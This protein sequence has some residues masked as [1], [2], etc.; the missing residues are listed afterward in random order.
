MRAVRSH[1]LPLAPITAGLAGLL[2]LAACSGDDTEPTPTPSTSAETAEAPEPTG[3][4]EPEPTE[5]ADDATSAG[6]D[7]VQGTWLSDPAAQAEQTTSGLGMADLGAQATVTGDSLT[8]ID[9]TSF[10]TEYR[11][12]VVEVTWELDGQEFRMVNSWSGRLTGTVTVTDDLFT[13]S[14]VDAGG[15][16]MS[17]ET[18]VNGTRLDVPG[19]EEIPATGFAAGGASTYTCDTDELRLTP[20]VEG[21]DAGALVTVLHRAD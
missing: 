19:L 3:T 20:Q 5:P 15:L 16:D 6:A 8:T 10:T 14:D 9:G 2:L 11:D 7:C 18:F 1:L 21:V 17:Y 4:S 13:V 12:Q